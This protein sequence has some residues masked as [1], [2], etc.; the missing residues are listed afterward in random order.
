MIERDESD[1]GNVVLEILTKTVFKFLFEN[2]KKE[3]SYLSGLKSLNIFSGFS[4]M[5]NSCAPFSNL[6]LDWR[7]IRMYVHRNRDEGHIN[8]LLCRDHVP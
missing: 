7:H 6:P 4:D 1:V 8:L 2:L 3:R 5:E